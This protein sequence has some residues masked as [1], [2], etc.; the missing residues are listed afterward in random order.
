M[1]R[2]RIRRLGVLGGT[3]DPLHN[4][5]LVAATAALEE[6]NL[7]RVLFVPAGQP[8]QK[9]SYT[10]HEDRY[11]M[12]VLGAVR[13]E[14][15]AVSRLELD[16]SGPTYTADT[17]QTLRD[18]YG[19]GVRLYFILGA[20]ALLGLDTWVGIER[21]PGL[22]EIIAVSRPGVEFPAR[23][24]GATWPRVHHLEIPGVDISATQVRERVK[25][26]LSVDD[27]VPVGVLRYIRE[28]RLYVNEK[29]AKGAET[30][31]PGRG[32]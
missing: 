20:D 24:E 14:R 16:R 10:H 21:L 29:E 1:D 9:A 25:S 18:W 5:H 2:G 12:T 28:H 30:S 26:G 22:A 7:D 11:L 15:F 17:M 31:P 4:G 32:R 8:W 3:F 6:F 23:P 13:D 27:H 19:P